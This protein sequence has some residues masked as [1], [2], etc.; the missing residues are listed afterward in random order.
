[1]EM[2]PC[3]LHV[4]S[5][6]DGEEKDKHQSS[7]LEGQAALWEVKDAHWTVRAHDITAHAGTVS[8]SRNP[9]I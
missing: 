5:N 8:H 1:M 3:L 4:V 6:D 9:W 7:A 2:S